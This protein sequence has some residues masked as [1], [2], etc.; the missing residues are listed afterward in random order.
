MTLDLYGS[1]KPRLLLTVTDKSDNLACDGF[2]RT[3]TFVGTK[4]ANFLTNFF[5]EGAIRQLGIQ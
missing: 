3:K 5:L 1:Q 2:Y 4:I